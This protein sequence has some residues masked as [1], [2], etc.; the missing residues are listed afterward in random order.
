M[1]SSKREALPCQVLGHNYIKLNSSSQQ[2][3]LLKCQH[4][5]IVRYTDPRGNFED[6]DI[7]NKAIQNTLRQLFHLRLKKQKAR[8]KL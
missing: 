8:V 7:P 1:I 6:R 4:C 3:S 2:S 5:G